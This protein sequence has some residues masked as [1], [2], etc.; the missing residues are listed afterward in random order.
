[1]RQAASFDVIVLGAGTAGLAS[2]WYA[3]RRGLSVAVIDRDDVVGGLASSKVVDGQRVDLGSH[4]LHPSIRPDLLADLR[5]LLGDELQWRQP[6]GRIRLEGRWLAFPI[7]STDLLRNAPMRLAL[8]TARDGVLG[9]WR[10]HRARRSA[11][12]PE[13]FGAQVRHDL[14]PTVAS[15]I[16]EP[17]ANKLWGVDAH[18]LSPELFRRRAGSRGGTALLRRLLRRGPRTGFWYPSGGFGRISEVL[19]NDLLARGGIVLLSTEVQRVDASYHGVTA[20]LAGG[21]SVRGRTLVTT[22]SPGSLLAMFAEAPLIVHE[23][24][25]QMRHRAAVLV[26]LSVPMH[27]YTDFE[28]HY[29][30]ESA[31]AVSRLSEPKAY[32]SSS[33]DPVGRTVL[34]AELPATVGDDLW[35]LAD[36]EIAAR[37]RSELVSAGLPDPVPRLVHVER[38]AGVHPVHELGFERRQR[39]VDA[40][41]NGLPNVLALRRQ[42]LFAQDNT[43]HAL[44]MGEGL[45]ACLRHDGSVDAKRWREA[46]AS[47]RTH[48]VES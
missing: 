18:E 10:A 14:G 43:H 7:R 44:A 6:G 31:V 15:A 22:T 42:M 8:G 48:L 41:T 32:R 13:S 2:A 1:M 11:S 19:A 26:Y 27:R 5:G 4:G 40:W 3:S 28:T 16:Y 39:V 21:G 25:Q 37:V 20:D 23:A 24:V 46:Q 36:D 38:R 45:A 12:P 9:P 33:A 34:C 17:F 35:N 30:P 47:F 29:F